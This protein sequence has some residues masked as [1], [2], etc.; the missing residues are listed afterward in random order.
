MLHSLI[1]LVKCDFSP[2]SPWHS[3]K[4]HVFAQR[5]HQVTGWN[6]FNS[7]KLSVNH[8]SFETQNRILLLLF[9]FSEHQSCLFPASLTSKW[10]FFS[11]SKIHS[12]ALTYFGYL[13]C[14]GDAW[15]PN[16]KYLLPNSNCPFILT[17]ETEGF[18]FQKPK[19]WSTNHLRWHWDAATASWCHLFFRQP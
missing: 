7:L 9:F 3:F 6:A 17:A 4:W 18:F 16:L 10:F 5:N 15:I 14:H 19:S 13:D 12:L 11:F 8:I 2:L 1:W